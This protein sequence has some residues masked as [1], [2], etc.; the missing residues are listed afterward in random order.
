M[1]DLYKEAI[2][3][4]KKLRELA[5]EDARKSIMEKVSPYIK[6]MIA[7]E[8]ASATSFFFEEDDDLSAGGVADPVGVTA[9]SAMPATMDDGSPSAVVD[10]SAMPTDSAVEGGDVSTTPAPISVMGSDVMN[11]PMPDADGKITIDFEQLF[12]GEGSGDTV[13]PV[14]TSTMPPGGEIPA[15]PAD[16]A[17]VAP[18]EDPALSGTVGT[19]PT[20]PATA[21]PPPASPDMVGA[22]PV[23]GEEE[24]ETQNPPPPPAA[25]LAE[26]ASYEKFKVALTEAAEKVDRAYYKPRLSD[27]TQES[28]KNRLF[29]LLESLDSLLESGRVTQS[30]ARL[31]EKRLEFLFLKLK[32]AG[33]SNSYTTDMDEKEDPMKKSLKEYAAQLFESD[34]QESLAKDSA[35]T[36]KT[37]LPTHASA[38]AQAEE[39]SGVSPEVE[40]LFKEEHANQDIMPGGKQGRHVRAAAG[41]VNSPALPN[42]SGAKSQK[43]PWEEGEP[44]VVSEE[45]EETKSHAG[46]GD[47]SEKPVAAPDMFFEIDE[48][49]L[50]EAV[51]AIRKENAEKKAAKK[52][53][54]W[55]K[56]KPEGKSKSSKAVLEKETV[57]ENSMMGGAG[58]EED[59]V[60]NVEL[61]DDIEDQL[62]VA[63]LDVDFELGGDEMGLEGEEEGDEMSL[64]AGLEDEGDLD[65]GGEE[66][67]M[68]LDL[69]D[70]EEEGG[71]PSH[72]SSMGSEE[73]DMVL[74]DEEGMDEMSLFESKLGTAR[75]LNRRMKKSLLENRKA[76]VAYK[77]LAESRVSEVKELKKEMAETNLFL[78]KLLYLNKFLQQEGLS[79]KVKQQIVEHLDKA[80]NVAEAKDIYGKIKRKLEESAGR[81]ST[82]VAG[83]ASK[84]TTAGSAKLQESA[85]TS[86][87]NGSPDGADPIVGTFER[88][89]KLARINRSED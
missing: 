61:P 51:A 68:S 64:D 41:S 82:S 85:R 43:K 19:E 4:A 42:A 31:N 83:S 47:S 74:A 65:V 9:D 67:E 1:S 15:P 39:Q 38:T 6:K 60:L 78:S 10:N 71:V 73:E 30:Q 45:V 75:K 21:P 2:M 55:E 16:A 59:L 44:E 66:D 63:D 11:V 28:L 8:A 62:D 70:E 58:M 35:S 69:G 40:D 79:R 52:T 50:R 84:P 86:Q 48:K 72:G 25:P 49:E 23:A 17:P 57:K 88:W 76:A 18:A 34:D 7:K 37:G 3:D 77:R 14:D 89:Q 53:A 81:S 54:G 13:S 56:G 33:L 36:G 24:D 46:F 29:S 80:T 26:R 20:E 87:A 5:E 22:A 12:S 27:I 32:E